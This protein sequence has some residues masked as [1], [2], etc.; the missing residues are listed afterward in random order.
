M[1]QISQVMQNRKVD[2]LDDMNS[3]KAAVLLPLIEHQGQLSILFEVR[4]E[5]LEGQPGEICFPG[6]H[7]EKQD[8]TPRDTAIRE[9]AEELGVKSA[10]ITVL[11]PLDILVQPSNL[12]IYPYVGRINPGTHLM[13]QEDEVA[14]IFYV[15]LDYLRQAEPTISYTKMEMSPLPDFPFHLLPNGKD[16]D[17]RQGLYP[18]YFYIYERYII[19]GLTARILAHF[20][21][22]IP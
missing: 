14:E 3:Y 22:L 18:V 15:P 11:G 12:I 17:W 4:S 19:W 16:Y 13:P 2:I 10:D 7:M 5:T 20:L 21:T 9:T 1:E 6:G 8:P